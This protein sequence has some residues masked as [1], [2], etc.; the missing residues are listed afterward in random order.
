[1]IRGRK[2]LYILH[3]GKFER[4]VE[5]FVVNPREMRNT[6]RTRLNVKPKDLLSFG[7]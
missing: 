7:L 5:I 2:Q 3:A 6:G 1:M 4:V